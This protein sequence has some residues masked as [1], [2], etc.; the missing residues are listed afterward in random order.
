MHDVGVEKGMHDVGVEK[1]EIKADLASRLIAEQQSCRLV[2]SN[3]RES[4]P[5]ALQVVR[6]RRWLTSTYEAKTK[7]TQL[8]VPGEDQH[9]N[10]TDKTAL[11]GTRRHAC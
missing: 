9:A 6:A 8:R 10:N 11:S 3:R 7:P 1:G 4:A 5:V 2:L